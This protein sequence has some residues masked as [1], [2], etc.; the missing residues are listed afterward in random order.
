M[1]KYLSKS[2]FLDR[3]NNLSSTLE[4]QPTSLILTSLSPINIDH[5]NRAKMLRNG[6]AIISF[7]ILEDFLKNRIGEVIEGI[8][9]SAIS[10]S[11]FHD[12]LKVATTL[13]A[14][15][16]ISY[17]AN[18]LKRSGDDWLTFIQQ[19][20]YK[21]S[22]SR[23]SR[24]K[25][26]KYSLGWN[27][28]NIVTDDI[29]KWLKIFRVKGG[30]KTIRELTSKAEVTLISPES[31]YK[32]A[33]LRR[34]AAAHSPNSDALLTDLIQFTNDAKAIALAFD[35]LVTFSLHEI[36]K[37]N[38]LLLNGC[39][40]IEASSVSFRFILKSGKNWKEFINTN[41]RA[42]KKSNNLEDAIKI[43]KKRPKKGK[44]DVIIVK[45]DL[46]SIIDWHYSYI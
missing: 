12:E 38:I 26:S 20:T 16:S 4:E 2:S 42:L 19:E 43:A 18:N 41:K 37:P 29:S 6:L 27:K 25:M 33:F 1:K 7:V 45:D 31:I 11:A 22:S 28:A 36:N 14:I 3:I 46:N 13:E 5:N 32:S 40:K 15:D 21:V 39:Y 30:W 9:S 10:F 35:I 34:N 24:Y 44:F 17:R 23:N 8:K